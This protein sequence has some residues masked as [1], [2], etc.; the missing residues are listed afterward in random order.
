M[1]RHVEKEEENM[2]KAV[3]FMA[4]CRAME[5]EDIEEAIDDDVSVWHSDTTSL[6][7]VLSLAQFLGMSRTAYECWVE[8]PWSL[9]LIIEYDGNLPEPQ[10]RAIVDATRII[11]NMD[12]KTQREILTL[13]EDPDYVPMFTDSSVTSA[14]SNAAWLHQLRSPKSKARLLRQLW[15]IKPMRANA[16]RKA[17]ESEIVRDW[18][19]NGSVDTPEGRAARKRA[20]PPVATEHPDTGDS[21]LFNAT[22][23]REY[24]ERLS[25]VELRDALVREAAL[26]YEQQER[27]NRLAHA[28]EQ[29][30]LQAEPFTNKTIVGFGLGYLVRPGD[31]IS[32][33][34]GASPLVQPLFMELLESY[35][36]SEHSEAHR[37]LITTAREELAAYAKALDETPKQTVEALANTADTSFRLR[38]VLRRVYDSKIESPEATQLRRSIEEFFETHGHPR[39]REWLM[40]ARSTSLPSEWRD[41][42]CKPVRTPGTSTFNRTEP[43]DCCRRCAKAEL[44]PVMEALTGILNQVA[45]LSLVAHG[46]HQL[47]IEGGLMRS[48]MTRYGND[49]QKIETRLDYAEPVNPLI[50]G[51]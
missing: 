33:A 5:V 1:L 36:T 13:L 15:A 26:R 29:R 18:A 3:N 22:K 21:P 38:Y 45:K 32:F 20:L 11:L 40:L 17:W 35:A 14:Y 4:R 49:N 41:C 8:L 16:F 24:I 23:Y 6:P 19:D 30:V 34:L 47:R 7:A 50:K 44:V 48:Y 46:T 10:L 25:V 2:G 12:E 27:A 42:A 51:E 43:N 39:D 31:K 37:L 9:P 28:N